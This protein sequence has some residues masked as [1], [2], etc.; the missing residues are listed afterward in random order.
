VKLWIRVDASAPND[1]KMGE[2]ADYLRTARAHAFGLV[3][4][5]WCAMAEHAVDGDLTGVSDRTLEEWAGWTG[6]RGRF[7][8]AFREIFLHKVVEVDGKMGVLPGWNER[9]GALLSRMERDRQRHKNKEVRPELP[10]DSPRKFHGNSAEIP[11]SLLGDSTST[12]R[13]VTVRTTKAS[14][15]AVAPTDNWV[16]S[17]RT[18]FLAVG[19]FTHGRIGKALSPVVQQYGWPDTERGLRDYVA[20]PK[21][22]RNRTPEYFAQESG[23]WVVGAREDFADKDG[24]PTARADRLFGVAS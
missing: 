10:P 5:V 13:N 11:Q 20:A 2:L 24:V 12:V 22:G 17:A 15:G 4:G 9:Q 1:P 8:A 16:D 21:N 23:T 7:A 19:T 14:S 3:S 18:V 6:K